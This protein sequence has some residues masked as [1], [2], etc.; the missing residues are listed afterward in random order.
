M[1][2]EEVPQTTRLYPSPRLKGPISTPLLILDATV[3]RFSATGVIFIF[4]TTP[5]GVAEDV[6]LD[7]LQSS[8]I[9]ALNSLPQWAGQ[10]QWAPVRPDG[11]H[12]E[13]FH[14]L[15]IVYG[16]ESDPGVEWA[17]VRHSFPVTSLAPAPAERASGS[18][19]WIVAN[20]PQEM[21]LSQTP[22]A[23][24]NLRDYEGL[25]GM[26]VQ[27]NLFAGG[28][29]AIG[30]KMA[31][32]LADAQALMVFVHNWAAASR[33]QY[34]HA[35][36]SLMD[37]PVFDPSQLDLRAA[38]DIDTSVADPALSAAA[39]KL[40]MHRFNWWG[41]TDPGYP[42]VLIPTTE[43]SKPPA[44]QLATAVLSPLTPG[45]WHT[46]NF[47]RPVTHALLH[48]TG[49]ELDR[50]RALARAD[51][52][53]RPDISRL[54]VLLAHIWAA[55][56]RA[57]G[58]LQ[59]A[60]VFLNITLGARP[61]VSPPLPASFIG[62]PIF[63]THIRAAGSDASTANVGETAAKIRETIKLFTPEKVGGNAP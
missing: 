26:L 52:R 47:T 50:L 36:V 3:A 39:R 11:G 34:G 61:R 4:D 2:A 19:I 42:D 58:H 28:G 56:N 29:Y 57:R 44:D 15:R 40:P 32:P 10:L 16:T 21:L 5:D 53:G 6:F 46:W 31:H 51:P 7:R 24:Y 12:T 49:A 22:L 9:T 60:D 17:V 20:F 62:S 30:I 8:F 1:V 63:L 38:G 48:F 18:G 41:T 23:L 55:I 45:P 14:R 35:M 27:I 54:D 13:R 25:P 37:P 59:S 33:A 43:A